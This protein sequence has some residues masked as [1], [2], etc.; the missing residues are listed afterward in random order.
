MLTHTA[1]SPR[2]NRESQPRL[3]I[4]DIFRRFGPT[5]R[6]QHHVTNA[7]AKVMRAIEACRTPLLGGHRR[8]CMDCGHQ[9]DEF[10]S[11]RNRHCPTC[12]ALPQAKWIAKRQQRV[13]PVRHFHVVFT[14]PAQLR[15]VA[16][17]NR[18]RVFALLFRTA[19][20]TL[21]E[22]GKD[23]KRLGVQLGITTVLHTWTRKL[24]FHPH[25]HC[26]VTAGGLAVSGSSRWIHVAGDFLF[27]VRVIS[28]LFRGKFLAGLD[29]LYKAGKLVVPVCSKDLAPHA[30]FQQL[31]DELYNLEWITYCKEPF[32][33]AQHVFKYLGRYTHRVAISNSRLI[34]SDD[35]GVSF[36]TKDGNSITLPPLEFIRRFL[37]HVLPN[38]FVKIRH[39]GLMASGNVNGRL[40]VARALLTPA[41]ADTDAEGAQANLAELDELSWEDLFLRLTGIDLRT[42]A[43]CG[44]SNTR[45]YRITRPRHAPFDTS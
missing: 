44:G 25:V 31:K 21:L 26:V 27:P 22:L 36:A 33:G 30:A 5:Y 6:Q 32:A 17:A 12:Q 45:R 9:V 34:S 18:E 11:C 15:P 42:C 4:G 20:D 23:P 29:E 19:A 38:R 35:D 8:V 24:Q 10:N 40:E 16:H 37:M 2:P 3:Q 13:L 41:N 1:G 43:A 7:Q 28:R 39:Y 14:L